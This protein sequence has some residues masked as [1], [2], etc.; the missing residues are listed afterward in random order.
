M[1]SEDR[2]LNLLRPTYSESKDG[3][4][5]SVVILA[6]CLTF[7]LVSEANACPT[8]SQQ[9]RIVSEL[10]RDGYKQTEMFFVDAICDHSAG[11]TPIPCSYGYPKMVNAEGKTSLVTCQNRIDI[12]ARDGFFLENHWSGRLEIKNESSF[13]L[14]VIGHASPTHSSID[15]GESFTVSGVPGGYVDIIPYRTRSHRIWFK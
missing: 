5:K 3:D 6:A 4:M 13:L 11:G 10:E 7:G 14:E 8:G 2:K 15:S 1:R 12:K 9:S